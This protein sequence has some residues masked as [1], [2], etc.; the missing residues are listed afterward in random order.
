[1][2]FY[3]NIHH[4]FHINKSKAQ[5]AFVKPLAGLLL[6]SEP[7]CNPHDDDDDCKDNGTHNALSCRKR[8]QL[9]QTCFRKG[10][11]DLNLQRKFHYF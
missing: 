7:S 9:Q 1:M 3:K 5:V 2:S 4:T 8:T 11:N 10:K 6:Y